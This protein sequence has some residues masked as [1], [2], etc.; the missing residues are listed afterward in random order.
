MA[1]TG[2]ARRERRARERNAG[3]RTSSA[4]ESTQRSKKQL[5]YHQFSPNASPNV[6]TRLL[7]PSVAR[8]TG[9]Q[10]DAR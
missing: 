9:A 6:L 3:Y 4:L 5:S 10:R 8:L 2:V 1:K 7:L